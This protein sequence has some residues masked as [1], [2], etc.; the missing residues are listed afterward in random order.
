M[1]LK[2]ILCP[3]LVL[4]LICGVFTGCTKTKIQSYNKKAEILSV[5]SGVIAANDKLE[6]SWDNDVKCVLLKNTES[7]KVWSNMPYEAYLGGSTYSTLTIVVQDMQN[8]QREQ[9][10]SEDIAK[11]G[12]ISCKKIDN[13]IELTYY[14]D[15][16]KI[17]VPVEYTLREDSVKV[18][19]DASK[20]VEGN[21]NF[22]LY[23]AAPASKFCSVLE[24]ET[25][26]Y[27]FAPYGSGAIINTTIQPDGKKRIEDEGNNIAALSTGS[28]VDPAE[29][30]GMQV[31]GIKDKADALLC[32]CEECAGAMGIHF[33]AGDRQ[34]DYSS[35]YPVFYFIDF[36]DVK[37]RAANSG[38]VR[39]L[40]ER[41]QS[42]MSVGFYPLTGENADY[43]GMA[44]KYRKYLIESGYV[45]E[46][47]SDKDF[48]SPY[49]VTLLGG[50]ETTSSILGIPVSTLKRMTTFSEAQNII[51]EL[52]E[53][54]GAKPVV[55]LQGFGESG[56]NIG[57]IAGGYKFASKLGSN[58]SRLAL[59]DYCKNNE[60][61]VYT[62]F[63]LVRYSKSGSGFSY[64][65]DSAKTAT[66][67]SA[68]QNGVNLPLR[69]YNTDLKHRLLS[70]GKLSKAVDKLV[71]LISKKSIS[72]VSL[73][74]LGEVTYSDYS[75]GTKYATTS[76]MDTDT[77]EF[78]E[79]LCKT[80]A[81]VAGAKST[82]FAAGLLDAVFDSPLDTSGKYQTEEDVPF[83]QMVLSGITPLYSTSINLD[84]NPE[85]KIMLA[86]ASGTG[87]GFSVI[88]DFDK[89]YM[90]NNVYKLYSCIYDKNKE[91]IK[92]VV[93]NYSEVYKAV[94]GSPIS[95]Y[96]ILDEN[97]SKTTFEN[98][99]V[100]YA[101][102]SSKEAE[103][104]AGVLEGYGFKMGSEG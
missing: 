45:R 34:S 53:Y 64:T 75:D 103:S 47:Y 30:S 5:E 58:K 16:V 42:K 52:S 54:V 86:A 98:G 74:T 46:N 83:Y 62:Q 51:S 91:Y 15:S 27:I 19:I 28:A 36:D 60:I 96:D 101:N 17:S 43:N 59:E 68:E 4:V 8:Y 3:L 26:A 79:R 33:F 48:S 77:K 13:G 71:S 25:D 10:S 11:K 55:R 85:R 93:D 38:D 76:L 87:L 7:G 20:V 9:F 31:F 80:S 18:S 92:N 67:H 81:G 32:I 41:T 88:N 23:Y 49:S 14:F 37:G 39:Q 82:Y 29:S 61:S 84:S 24:E 72:G 95:R 6:L 73:S 65:F 94:A 69:D 104:P 99:V 100:V 90:E 97:I 70:R 63:D 22:R 21:K 50:V 102:H 78:V 2:R 12:R 40:S 56:I 44:K 89:S 1:T 35:I 57:K 66:L